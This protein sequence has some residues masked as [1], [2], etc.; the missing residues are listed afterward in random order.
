LPF[1]FNPAILFGHIAGGAFQWARGWRL[2]AP[3]VTVSTQGGIL[4]I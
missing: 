2:V 4:S 1:S 3:G